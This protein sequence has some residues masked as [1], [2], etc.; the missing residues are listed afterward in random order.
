MPELPNGYYVKT[1]RFAGQTLS[2]PEIDPSAGGT[3]DIIL[4]DKPATVSGTVRDEKGAP[5]RLA[6]VDLWSIDNQQIRGAA[7]SADGHFQFANLPPGEYRLI[8]SEWIEPGAIE[9]P[10]L[11]AAFES[12][13]VHLT[14][15]EGTQQSADLKPISK[16]AV[17]A[18][19][20]KVP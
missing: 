12:Q 2:T 9:N 3:L 10:A 17:E 18:A 14:V 8:A 4:S 16:P 15:D 5:I 7:T 6:E 19:L 1:M 11:R 20:A 13:A